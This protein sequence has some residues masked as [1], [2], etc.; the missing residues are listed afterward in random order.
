MNGPV[1]EV[2]TR[3]FEVENDT[4]IEYP[5][6]LILLW[7]DKDIGLKEYDENGDLIRERDGFSD[8]ST[9]LTYQYSDGILLS[10]TEN[11]EIAYYK[12]DTYNHISCCKNRFY[13]TNESGQ[14]IQSD[15]Y[16]DVSP[17]PPFNRSYIYNMD[18]NMISSTTTTLSTNST[19][20]FES[21]YN[22]DGLLIAQK[23]KDLY[24][25]EY[26]ITYLEYDKNSNWIKRQ[27]IEEN[28]TLNL[29]SKYIQQRTI[30]Y[31]K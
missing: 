23:C 31:Y 18:G 7:G 6:N 21:I 27:I 29:T 2:T 22:D 24:L 3:T 4:I 11:G 26:I 16:F 20:S 12:Y 19:S 5:E 28:H 15:E 30:S 17:I 8:N 13:K 25:K 10:C 14:I 1:H 9:E